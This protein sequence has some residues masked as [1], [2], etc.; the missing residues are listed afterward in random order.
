MAAPSNIW[1]ETVDWYSCGSGDGG[2]TWNCHY[3]SSETTCYSDNDDEAENQDY[4]APDFAA[5]GGGN[6]GS[7]TTADIVVDPNL[8]DCFKG[9]IGSVTTD[10][11]KSYLLKIIRSM[12]GD[13]AGAR[14]L[15]FKSGSAGGSLGAYSESENTIFLDASK[16]GNNS[17]EYVATVL[18]HELAH[19][20][21]V[22]FRGGFLSPSTYDQHV[23]IFQ[24]MV[25]NMKDALKEVYPNLSDTD[26]LSLCLQGMDDYIRDQNGNIRAEVDRAAREK[27]GISI[28][29]ARANANSY[30][31]GTK[32]TRCTQ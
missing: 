19:V 14:N 13:N 28:A 18:F 17:N 25:T 6:S 8:N 30:A 24:T 7:A 29:D 2:N 23:Q 22:E 31:N 16:L 12:Y 5:G 27:Y 3:E 9:V 15:S 11:Y 10:R 20:L 26:A 21:I 4:D 32:G 1:C